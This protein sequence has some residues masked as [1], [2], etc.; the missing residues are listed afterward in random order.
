MQLRANF[1][2]AV[3]ARVE[4]VVEAR[5]EARVQPVQAALQQQNQHMAA[6]YAY[7][8]SMASTM[9]TPPQMTMPPPPMQF[10]PVPTMMP[11][12]GYSPVSLLT[13]LYF[14]LAPQLST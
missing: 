9:P 13:T 14:H 7:M 8:Q 4:A 1:E 3:E 2:A 12:T 11:P 6:M 10:V 5:V